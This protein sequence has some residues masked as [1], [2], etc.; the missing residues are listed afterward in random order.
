MMRLIL[1]TLYVVAAIGATA[2]PAPVPKGAKKADYFPLA[3]GHKWEYIEDDDVKTT[4]VM[5]VTEEENGRVFTITYK[6]E[7]VRPPTAERVFRVTGGQVFSLR[8]E[9]SVAEKAAVIMK[10]SVRSGD[11]WTTEHQW[12]DSE[13]WTIRHKVG[14]AKKI[15][16]PAGEFLALPVEH[17]SERLTDL[18]WYADGVGLIRKEKDG[19]VVTELKSFTPAK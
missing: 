15:K 7:K 2:R 13:A 1:F 4:E 17:I 8:T 12:K 18:R 11:E 5:A 6:G 10:L 3:V 9:T 19:K 14:D 16:T